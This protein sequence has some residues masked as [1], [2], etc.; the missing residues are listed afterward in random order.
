VN[1]LIQEIATDSSLTDI[2]YYAPSAWLG[3]APFLRFLL[4]D[5]DPDIYVEL[6]THHGFSYF[7]ACQAIQEFGLS[8]TSFA[9]DHWEGDPHAGAISAVVFGQV[10]DE[11]EKYKK[12]SRLYK[13]HFA[14]ALDKFG[15]ATI[16]I[17]HIDG[18]HTYESVAE[19]F[20]AWKPKMT[21]NGIILFHDIHVYRNGFGVYKLWSELKIEYKTMEFTGSHGLGILFLGEVPQGDTR[22]LFHLTQQGGE[23]QVQGVFQSLGDD[24]IQKLKDREIQSRDQ[25]LNSFTASRAWRLVRFIRKGRRFLVSK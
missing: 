21:P 12:F 4:R 22:N 7:A 3:H 17:L 13:M 25:L 10:Q 1:N 19:D 14:D 5:V 11:N 24:L 8:T 6:G 20:F 9:I 18:F 2:D 16:D 23:Y 15:L